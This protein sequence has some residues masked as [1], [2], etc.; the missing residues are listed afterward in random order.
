MHTVKLPPLIPLPSIISGAALKSYYSDSM[1]ISLSV[2][3]SIAASFSHSGNQLQ[4]Q[5][6][7]CTFVLMP[8]LDH[9]HKK[10]QPLQ[11]TDI[12]LLHVCVCVHVRVRDGSR[13]ILLLPH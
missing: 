13:C 10:S 6:G 8:R 1:N 9:C 2:S 3:L 11:S 7:S 5:A 12:H 4:W